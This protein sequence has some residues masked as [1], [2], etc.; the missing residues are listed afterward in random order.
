M[1]TGEDIRKLWELSVGSMNDCRRAYAMAEDPAQPFE[2][3]T[4][5][6]HCARSTPTDSPSTSSRR[7][8]GRSGTSTS[9]PSARRTCAN[10]MGRSPRPTPR[11]VPHPLLDPSGRTGA[12]HPRTPCAN[13][14]PSTR[15]VSCPR[16]VETPIVGRPGEVGWLRTRGQEASATRGKRA[17]CNGSA[18]VKIMRDLKAAGLCAI[19]MWRSGRKSGAKVGPFRA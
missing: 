11:R 13:R 3:A 15:R 6:G 9:A 10:A 12:V 7:K 17:L 2:T 1:A 5:S 8:P 16:N 19:S 14:G 18:K 4:C